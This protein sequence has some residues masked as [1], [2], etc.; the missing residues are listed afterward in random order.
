MGMIANLGQLGQ[1]ARLARAAGLTP[2]MVT[3]ALPERT[4]GVA[5][6]LVPRLTDR[7]AARLGGGAQ[8]DGAALHEALLTAL[9]AETAGKRPAIYDR[10]VDGL[11]RL[12]RPLTMLGTVALVGYAIA[13]PAGF[14][15]R[16]EGLSQMPDQMWWLL[17]AVVSLFFGAREAHHFRLTKALEVL[18]PGQPATENAA[19]EPKKAGAEN[20]VAAPS[21][22]SPSP[23]PVAA[24]AVAGP[25]VPAPALPHAATAADNPALAEWLRLEAVRG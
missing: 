2:E 4:Q 13:D 11:N 21:S 7:L 19:K 6:V 22:P 25:A 18:F 9:A 17:G 10:M 23:T 1:A 8:P 12:P 15:Q 5:Q 3:S 16:M 24:P 14:G 20:P